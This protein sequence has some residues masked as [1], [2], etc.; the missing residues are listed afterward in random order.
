ML[1]RQSAVNN[2][3][4]EETRP[5]LASVGFNIN[6]IILTIVSLLHH[7][8]ILDTGPMGTWYGGVATKIIETIICYWHQSLSGQSALMMW[9]YC[10]AGLVHCRA[11][12]YTRLYLACTAGAPDTGRGGLVPGSPDL[13]VAYR[14]SLDLR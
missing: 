9:N 10:T 11:L 2:S 4:E 13:N 3:S 6:M 12:R 7:Q 5:L 14:S 1:Q 8:V